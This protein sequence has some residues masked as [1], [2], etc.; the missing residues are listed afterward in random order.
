MPDQVETDIRERLAFLGIGAAEKVLISRIG[1]QVRQTLG[2]ALDRFYR[3][4]DE[5][6]ALSRFFSNPLHQKS[7]R[8]QQEKHW[9]RI[10]DGDFGADYVQS[11]KAIGNTHA[12]IGLE[13]QWY[14]GSY[15][16]LLEGIV[17]GFLREAWP[18]PPQGFFDRLF[19]KAKP[20]LPVE[21]ATRRVGLLIKAALLDMELGLQTYT[22]NMDDQERSRA[23]K[24]RTESLTALSEALADALERMAKGDLVQ[25]I[26]PDLETETTRMSG[27]FQNACAGLSHIVHAVRSTSGV[28]E[29]RARTLSSSSEDVACRIAEQVQALGTVSRNITELTASVKEVAEE[30]RQADETVEA[31][32]NETGQGAEIVNRTVEAM[33]KISESSTQIVQI[34]SVIDEI[35]FQTNLL[36]LNAG[37]E[38]ARA[39]DAGRGFA[40]VAQEIRALAQRSTTAAREIKELI[41]SSMEDV[42]RGVKMVDETGAALGNITTSVSRL[43]EAVGEIASGAEE[44]ALRIMEINASTTQL[45]AVTKTNAAIVQEMSGS[46]QELVWDAAELMKIVMNFKVRDDQSAL[47]QARTGLAF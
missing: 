16:L 3:R 15:G 13:P 33:A 8:T 14:I 2:P 4:V 32:C 19:R 10:L 7:A 22:L 42:E 31:C 35:A 9:S 43:G 21:E 40:V 36:A 46:S 1:Q 23:E 37:V 24:E 12:R 44:Q 27:A 11:T 5:T 47:S 30:A 41:S 45:E 34:I 38:A 29:H 26:D 28:V 39:G 25:E 6:P 18:Q 20:V 17:S